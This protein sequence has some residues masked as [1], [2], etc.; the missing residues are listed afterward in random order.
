MQ[1]PSFFILQVSALFRPERDRKELFNMT[2]LKTA[3]LAA[4]M[5]VT[6]HSAGLA[7]ATDDWTVK[8]AEGSVAA[9]VTRLTIAASDAGVTLFATIDH[10]AGAKLVGEEMG[11]M[12]L[13]I[14]GNPEIGTPILKATPEAGLDLPIRVLIWDDGGKTQIGYLTPEALKARYDISGADEALTKMGDAL[15][16][17]TD[18]A[19]A[20]E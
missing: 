6:A 10:A 11:D 5:T 13:V 15:D 12:T 14:F 9:T 1:A 8:P 2:F 7:A 17:L 18:A 19:A 3:L 20:G 16:T 4:T